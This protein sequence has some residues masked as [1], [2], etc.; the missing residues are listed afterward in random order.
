MSK[1]SEVI[2]TCQG[3]KDQPQFNYEGIKNHLLV[4]HQIDTA[5]LKVAKSM[6][7]HI[8]GRDYYTTCYDLTFENGFRISSSERTTRAKNDPM[9]Y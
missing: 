3:C 5:N 7:M 9:R 2:Y 6:T 4:M 8:D 1:K